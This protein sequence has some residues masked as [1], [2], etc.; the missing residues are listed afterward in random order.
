MIAAIGF[1][2]DQ[3]GHRGLKKNPLTTQLGS[4]GGLGGPT[5]KK[6]ASQDSQE[7]KDKFP[8]PPLPLQFVVT[9]GEEADETSMQDRSCVSRVKLAM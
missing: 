7:G 4:G 1:P 8:T 6:M 9:R 5:G 3:R 2:K